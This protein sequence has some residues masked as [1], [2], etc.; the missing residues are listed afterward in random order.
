M[1]NWS[2]RELDRFV[3]LFCH[4]VELEGN[5]TGLSNIKRIGRKCLALGLLPARG[6]FGAS[7]SRNIRAML[8]NAM[9]TKGARTPRT[10]RVAVRIRVKNTQIGREVEYSSD[11]AFVLTDLLLYYTVYYRAAC[12]QQCLYFLPEPQGQ[13]SLRPIFRSAWRYAVLSA[14]SPAA[15]IRRCGAK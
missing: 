8:S 4:Q 2:P 11:A 13:E 1:Q 5:G 15:T 14:P 3:N 7:G 12:P 6:A 10:S 9:L